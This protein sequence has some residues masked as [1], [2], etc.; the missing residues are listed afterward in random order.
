MEDGKPLRK[1]KVFQEVNLLELLQKK[2]KDMEEKQKEEKENRVKKEKD[3][4][5]EEEPV[6]VNLFYCK[7][8]PHVYN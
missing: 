4:K 8:N 7:N 1:S 5:E 2:R 6:N 3:E